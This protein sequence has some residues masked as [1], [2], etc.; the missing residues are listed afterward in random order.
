MGRTGGVGRRRSVPV[1]S[2]V[3]F[4]LW[5]SVV[6]LSSGVSLAATIVQSPTV[7]RPVLKPNEDDRQI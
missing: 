1:Y 7:S 3:G 6:G 4:R 5:P 2:E